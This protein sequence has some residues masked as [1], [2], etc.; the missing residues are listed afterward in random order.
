MN[1]LKHTRVVKQTIYEW[2]NSFTPLIRV[3]LRAGDKVALEAPKAK[4]LNQCAAAQFTDFEQSILVQT[5]ER[6]K[7][8]TLTLGD[9]NMDELKKDISSADAKF[10]RPYKPTTQIAEYLTARALRQGV[11]PPSFLNGVDKVLGKRKSEHK[12]KGGDKRRGKGGDRR[13]VYSMEVEDQEDWGD[14]HADQE[15]EDWAAD[16]EHEAF[17][18][19]A[20]ASRPSFPPCTTQ[21]CIDKNISHTHSLERCYKRQSPNRFSGKGS[22]GSK[23]KGR[24]ALLFVNTLLLCCSIKWL[25]YGKCTVR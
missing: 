5:N 1:I 18:F 14:F 19:Q 9:F 2:C 15:S 7:A 17:A 10:T 22:F 11:A 4:R 3:Y 6:W 13:S 16:D 21:Y 24:G 8:S 12:G 25:M 23:G 20:G